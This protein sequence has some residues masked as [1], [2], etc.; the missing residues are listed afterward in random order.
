MFA[1]ICAGAIV[2]LY[3][4]RIWGLSAMRGQEPELYERLGRPELVPSHWGYFPSGF[5]RQVL[6]DPEFGGLTRSTQLVF[7][8]AGLLN[9]I[10]SVLFGVII[11][12]MVLMGIVR[13]LM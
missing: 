7:R 10:A 4:L 9:F 2:V 5:L 1:P 6:N 8:A 3:I 11:V 12:C 13:A